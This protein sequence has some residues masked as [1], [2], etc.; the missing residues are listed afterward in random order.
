MYLYILIVS[1]VAIYDLTFDRLF[2]PNLVD[3][4][5]LLGDAEGSSV[6]VRQWRLAAPLDPWRTVAEL[7]RLHVVLEFRRQEWL[8]GDGEAPPPR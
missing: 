7:P 1:I 4:L 5:T 8:F 2:K 6:T 3:P